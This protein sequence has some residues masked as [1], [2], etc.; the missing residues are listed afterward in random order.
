MDT[1]FTNSFFSGMRALVLREHAWDQTSLP[2]QLRNLEVDA[3]FSPCPSG[4]AAILL[5]AEQTDKPFDI[6][7]I[8]SQD[9]SR[10]CLNLSSALC[11]Q[12]ASPPK[13]ILLTD[14][15]HGFT[16]KRLTKSGVDA[17]LAPDATASNLQRL[18]K[19]IFRPSA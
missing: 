10:K 19:S 9:D 2:Q 5:K 11:L 14:A 8:E 13:V 16:F 3:Q 17:V 18:L 1:S 4:A 6:L 15:T 7:L 12:L